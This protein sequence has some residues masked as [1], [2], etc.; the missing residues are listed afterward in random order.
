M[1]QARK[2]RKPDLVIGFQP[3]GLGNQKKD[4]K[5]ELNNQIEFDQ[6]IG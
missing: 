4:H 2:N 5:K 1:T 6:M 3:S